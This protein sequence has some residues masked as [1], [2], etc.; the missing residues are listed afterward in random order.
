M[1]NAGDTYYESPDDIHVVSRNPSTTM[2]AK[3]LIF[4]VHEK[5][6]PLSTPVKNRTDGSSDAAR[7]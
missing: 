1:L 2:G 5:G 4:I 6:M 7:S 3:A